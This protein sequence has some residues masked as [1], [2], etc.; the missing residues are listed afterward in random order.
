MVRARNGRKQP[1]TKPVTVDH[2]IEREK[3]GARAV[4]GDLENPHRE[5]QG[6]DVPVSVEFEN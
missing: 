4:R 3:D 1:A 5:G 2:D 6:G